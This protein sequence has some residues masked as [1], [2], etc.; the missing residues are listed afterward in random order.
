MNLAIN[1]RM[2][3]PGAARSRS[4]PRT[5]ISPRT[6]PW[7]C[8]R[9][10]PGRYVQLALGDSGHGMDEA[11]AAQAFE[12]FFAT[13]P[14]D[15][16]TGLGSPRVC[17]IVVQ[18]GGRVAVESQPGAGTIMRVF[19]PRVDAPGTSAADTVEA[20]LDPRGAERVLLVEDEEYVRELVREFLLTAGYTV[21]EAATAEEA[22]QVIAASRVEIDLLIADVVLPG[23][24]GRALADDLRHQM[25]RLETLFMSGYPGD[26]VFVGEAFHPGTAFLPKPFTRHLLTR[27]VREVLNARR[28][29]VA[30]VLL[31]EPDDAIR[32][33]LGRMLA[34]A[35]YRVVESGDDWA[36]PDPSVAVVIVDVGHGEPLQLAALRNLRH[37]YPD[38][39]IVA[40]TGAFTT[41]IRREALDAGATVTLQKPLTDGIVLDA[42]ARAR[43][44]PTPDDD[45]FGGGAS[46]PALA[47]CG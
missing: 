29:A 31:A 15:H 5:S 6:T 46:P 43:R 22:Q 25:P 35:G 14:L 32:R 19:L 24:S 11:T 47:S 41:T 36:E 45:P 23:R 28:P 2:P 4:R 40:M 18:H 10:P 20:A 30:T 33:L 16:G 44:S 21:L 27:K 26:S 3:C 12:P 13:K 34:A 9:S 8:A 17:G 37:R 42:V 38:A 1:A 7:P 39:G